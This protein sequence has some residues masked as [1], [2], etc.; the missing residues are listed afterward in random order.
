MLD[1]LSIQCADVAASATGVGT[2]T[3]DQIEAGRGPA[4]MLMATAWLGATTGLS[5]KR[6]RT[7]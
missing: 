2:E 4:T 5:S 3:L 1:H 7:S 6:G